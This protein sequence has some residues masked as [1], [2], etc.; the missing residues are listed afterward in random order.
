MLGTL[1]TRRRNRYGVHLCAVASAML[2]LF[3]VTLLYNRLTANRRGPFLNDGVAVFDDL[4]AVEDPLLQDSDPDL[5]ATLS[6]DRIDELDVIDDD[7][8]VSN[9]EEILRVLESEGEENEHT[10]ISSTVSSG[11]FFDHASHV[12]RRTFDGKSIDEFDQWEAH[13]TMFEAGIASEE[14][15]SKVA[16]GSDDMPVDEEVR[17]KVVKVNKIEDVLLLKLDSHGSPLREGWAAWFDAKSV[18]L[19]KD[20]M[21]RSSLELLNPVNNMHL[22]DPDGFGVT[23]LTRGDKLVLKEY[24]H[25]LKKKKPLGG[26]NI[27]SKEA[28]ADHS[29]KMH[30]SVNHASI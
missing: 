22:Q 16:F 30:S 4:F 21:F 11:Y 17:R 5:R 7:S 15:L 20:R 10:T 28:D 13:A 14:K 27:E 9:E 25:R 24:L 26:S 29:A 1:R 23:G 3:S 8:K 6:D 18:F 19:R 12:I 2:L